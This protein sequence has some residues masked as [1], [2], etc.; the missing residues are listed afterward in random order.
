[1]ERDA[2]ATYQPLDTLKRIADDVW[3]IDGPTIPFGPPLLKMPFPTRM[4][5]VRIG[6]DLLFH[7][8]TRLT[9]ELRRIVEG[10]GRPRW[11][12]GPNRIHYW[13]IPDWHIAFT[14]AEVYLAP[15][16]REQAGSRIDFDCQ[17][18][19]RD[20]GY[21]WDSNVAT[22]PVEGSYMTEVVFFHRRSRTLVVTDLI[23]NFEPHK[24]NSVF[25]RWLTRL[26]C[27]QDPNGSM[28]RDMRATYR[29]KARLRFAVETMIGWNPERI[30][31]AHG[32][33]YDRNGTD[34]LRRA[35][36]WLLR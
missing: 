11:V 24:L 2:P 33:W 36:R 25:M 10:L 22:L 7:S 30:I 13:W 19:D 14:D 9:P 8:P 18:L 34:E 32:R 26:G 20:R 31:L 27:A 1:M 17:A 15:R 4:T 12:I 21:P 35:F 5:I 16:I 6:G 3:I 28:P 29:D 23:E